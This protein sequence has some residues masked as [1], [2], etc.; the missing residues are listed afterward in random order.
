MVEGAEQNTVTL[1]DINGRTLATK[2]DY[3][4]PLRFD[5][6]ATGTYMVKIGRHAAR[7]IVV[8]K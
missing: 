7:K 1:L 3:D 5:V 2:Q 4:A 6:P 8:V